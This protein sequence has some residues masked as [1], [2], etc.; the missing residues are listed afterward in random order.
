[1][2]TNTPS[3]PHEILRL[4][5]DYIHLSSL[6]AFLDISFQLLRL[7]LQLHTFAI[8]FSLRLLE[9][10]LV[11]AQTLCGRHA[12]AKGPFHDL[13]DDQQ[14][15][16]LARGQAYIHNNPKCEDLGIKPRAQESCG[17]V[18]VFEVVPATSVV[19]PSFGSGD[20][21]PPSLLLVGQVLCLQLGKTSRASVGQPSTQAYSHNLSI[22]PT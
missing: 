20:L 18:S 11:L 15:V 21:G 19:G 2:L 6:G 5:L 8:E 7:V 12:L 22:Y 1:M 13:Y 3:G 16:V 17:G 4:Y 10:A 14:L 9:G